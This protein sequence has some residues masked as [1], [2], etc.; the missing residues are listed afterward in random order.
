MSEP[1]SPELLEMLVCPETH[2]PVKAAPPE[3]LQ[4]LTTLQAEGKLLNRRGDPVAESPQAAL[5]R[6]DGTT[7][8]LVHDGIPVMLID[9]AI[10][11]DQL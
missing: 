7:A 11:L 8:Y 6:E 5:I 2:Q 4:R 1:I 10:A 3:T 9:E